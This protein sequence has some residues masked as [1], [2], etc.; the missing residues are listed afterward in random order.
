[1]VYSV[2]EGWM[3]SKSQS[4][5]SQRSMNLLLATW[6]SLI[7]KKSI[8]REKRERRVFTT[9]LE[10]VSGLEARLIS[11]SDEEVSFIADLVSAISRD[12]YIA[13]FVPDTEGCIQRQVR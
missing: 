12:E 11:S 9:L 2:Q 13:H 5:L 1:M 7:T 8:F 10:M 4:Q 3:K 6:E